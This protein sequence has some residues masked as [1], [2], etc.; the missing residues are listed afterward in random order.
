MALDVFNC[1]IDSIEPELVQTW[2]P[3]IQDTLHKLKEDEPSL[4][5]SPAYSKFLKG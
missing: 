3:V 2:P 5:K 1:L 4:Q